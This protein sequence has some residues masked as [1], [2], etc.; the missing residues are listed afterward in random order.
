MPSGTIEAQLL[1]IADRDAIRDL[2]RRYAHHVW[3]TEVPEAIALFS[4]DGQMDT[5]EGQVI[6]GRQAL[7]DS[8]GDML[9]D[10]Q[11]HPFVHNHVI[12]LDGDTAAGT[13][14]LDLR[15]VMEGRSMIGSG[16]YE[17]RYVRVEGEWK[18]QS[19]KLT[20]CYLVPITEGWAETDTDA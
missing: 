1:E 2:A 20:M 11:F 15:A 10:A 19:R 17:D 18:F 6:Q 4:Q 5:G 16:F 9:G 8:Y 3:R 14:Y 7:L 13:C 12:E